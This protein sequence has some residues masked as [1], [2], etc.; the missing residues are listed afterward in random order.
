MKASVKVS[1]QCSNEFG[2][3]G[4]EVLSFALAF[5]YDEFIV[6]LSSVSL[7]EKP[8]GYVP[9]PGIDRDGS[10]AALPTVSSEGH[11][12]ERVGARIASSCFPTLERSAHRFVR[13]LAPGAID[14]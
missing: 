1:S 4:R 3:L 10:S 2:R 6:W 8:G 5:G 13:L 7:P 9:T 14:P 12:H 11:S